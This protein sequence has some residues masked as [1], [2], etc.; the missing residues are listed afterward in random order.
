M[1][2]FLIYLCYMLDANIN[3]LNDYELLDGNTSSILSVCLDSMGLLL[4]MVRLAEPY[5]WVE[6]VAV[7]GPMLRCSS[8]QRK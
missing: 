5:V 7:F 3:F 4:A 1:L 6:F 2:Y 8:K